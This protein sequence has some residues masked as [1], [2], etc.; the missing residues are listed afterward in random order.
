MENQNDAAEDLNDSKSIVPKKSG[1]KISIWDIACFILFTVGIV[2]LII[3]NDAPILHYRDVIII[4]TIAAMV[5]IFLCFINLTRIAA[6]KIA[7]LI[8]AGFMLAA[9]WYIFFR[10]IPKYG[11]MDGCAI[12][13]K[14]PKY[15]AATIE[16]QYYETPEFSISWNGKTVASPTVKVNS[17]FFIEDNPF[18]GMGY[19]LNVIKDGKV[20]ALIGFDSATGKYEVLAP[21]D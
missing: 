14:D 3:F 8:L 1:I 16:P 2:F 5:I 20:T 10:Y 21:K 12:V 15:A 4:S 17:T 19:V 7:A 6:V 9:G 18:W 11:P 13:K